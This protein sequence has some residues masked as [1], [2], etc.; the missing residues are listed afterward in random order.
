MVD[1]D[2]SSQAARNVR[3]MH[4]EKNVSGPT[5]DFRQPQVETRW[6]DR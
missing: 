6:S 5:P 1:P 3:G 4:E 2:A